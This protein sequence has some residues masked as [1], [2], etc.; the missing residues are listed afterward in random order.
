MHIEP[1]FGGKIRSMPFVK[2]YEYLILTGLYLISETTRKG[3][4]F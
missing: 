4:N 3:F 2:G 1:H